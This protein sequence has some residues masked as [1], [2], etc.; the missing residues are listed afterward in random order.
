MG[1]RVL[2]AGWARDDLRYLV[3]P[4]QQGILQFDGR[5]TTTGMRTLH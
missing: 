5:G 4:E 1:R 3:G 2:R